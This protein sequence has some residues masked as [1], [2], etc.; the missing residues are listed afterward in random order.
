MKYLVGLLFLSL[1]ANSSLAQTKALVREGMT[2]GSPKND[3][4]KASIQAETEKTVSVQAEYK[5]FDEKGKAYKMTATILNQLKKP[6]KEFEPLSIDLDQR[7]G[8]VDFVFVFK[9]RQ[10]ILYTPEGIKSSYIEFS[11]S[12]KKGDEGSIFST[13]IL[14]IG[15][16]KAIFQL[17]KT[18]KVKVATTVEV[19]LVPFKSAV[20]IKP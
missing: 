6:M 9:Q 11:V 1:L 8:V 15:A 12:E 10:G 4:T 14:G 7:G 3:I 20:S 18:W 19:K 13:D 16:T 2:I 5:G 17:R